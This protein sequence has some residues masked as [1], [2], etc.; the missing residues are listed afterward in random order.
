[1]QVLGERF[2]RYDAATVVL[3]VI[4]VV[5]VVRPAVL[6]GSAATETDVDDSND[7]DN[8]DE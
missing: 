2:T 1:M 6:F 4:G 5:F 3:S 7:S 8:A